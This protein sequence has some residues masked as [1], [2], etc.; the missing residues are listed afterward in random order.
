MRIVFAGT[1]Q[2]AVPTLDALAASPHE[3]PLVVTRNDAPQGRRRRLTPSPVAQ[4]ATELGLPVLKTNSLDAE[5]VSKIRSTEPDIGVIVAFG[6]LVRSDLLQVPP[7]GWVNLH[8]SALP[9]WRGAA[10]VQQALIHGDDTIGVSVF[11]LVEAL[12]EGDV[13]A[14]QTEPIPP[15]A[16]AGDLLDSLSR[17]GAELMVNAL[18]TIS[19]GDALPTPQRG[20]ST[21]AAKLS[22]SD[23]RLVVTDAADAVYNR[24]RGVTPAPGAYVVTADGEERIKIHGMTRA[25]SDAPPLEPGTIAEHHGRVLLGTGT[26]PLALTRVQPPGKPAMDAADWWRGLRHDVHLEAE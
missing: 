7:H 9:R 12:D 16:T 10:P 4:R 2:A 20:P 24:F 1:P 21:Y 23:A 22:S 11:Q 13:W 14:T 19:T 3:V 25:P 15:D 26:A 6:A 8:F 5:A 17:S 18:E